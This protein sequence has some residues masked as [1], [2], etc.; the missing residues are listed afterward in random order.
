MLLVAVMTSIKGFDILI[1]TT[2]ATL[3]KRKILL[4]PIVNT[5]C[6]TLDLESFIYAAIQNRCND[7]MLWRTRL[8]ILNDLKYSGGIS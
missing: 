6:G 5:I 7:W 3:K 8:L 4:L 2:V 1:D